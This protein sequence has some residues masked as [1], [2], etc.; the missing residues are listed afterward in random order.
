MLWPSVV[1]G[2]RR[3]KQAAPALLKGRHPVNHIRRNV[4]VKPPLPVLFDRPG[5]DP[6]AVHGDEV[7]SPPGQPS[8]HIVDEVEIHPVDA[9]RT[10]RL[11]RGVRQGVAAPPLELVCQI[12]ARLVGDSRGTAGD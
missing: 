8:G 6:D 9:T 10:A 12:R 3:E 4:P 5:V 2:S 11:G 7:A 1:L